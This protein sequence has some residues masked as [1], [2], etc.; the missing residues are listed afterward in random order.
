MLRRKLLARTFCLDDLRQR[1]T[2][3]RGQNFELG[4]NLPTTRYRSV[5]VSY[6]RK[7]VPCRPPSCPRGVLHHA[8]NG[9][10][11]RRC[12]SNSKRRAAK[13]GAP[14]E[15]LSRTGRG[16]AVRAGAGVGAG[17]GGARTG[18]LWAPRRRSRVPAIQNLGKGRLSACSCGC[19]S[20]ICWPG[21]ARV[22]EK[23]MKLNLHLHN[24]GCHW[25]AQA[26]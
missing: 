15:Y 4:F 8:L 10:S 21:L 6:V 20:R 19:S 1:I 7:A 26:R 25:Q 22:W 5:S 9:C 24:E 14:A 17:V 13:S 16:T 23:L 3:L 18:G 2:L 12:V 11:S